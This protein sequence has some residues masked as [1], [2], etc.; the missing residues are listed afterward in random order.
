MSDRRSFLKK[1]AVVASALSLERCGEQ[2]GTR[3]ASAPVGPSTEP[4][5]EAV[6]RI[7]LPEATL[8][9]AGLTRVVEG[10][11]KWLR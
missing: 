4:I 10:F 2:G 3:D 9:E 1:T 5:L 8:G 7:V 11:R 6:A